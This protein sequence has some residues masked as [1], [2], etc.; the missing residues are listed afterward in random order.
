MASRKKKRKKNKEPV[1]PLGGYSLESLMGLA[2]VSVVKQRK[3]ILGLPFRLVG[4]LLKLP[5]VLLGLPFK[6]L[7]KI[8]GRGRKETT[9]EAK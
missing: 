7:G 9:T 2:P 4:S 6:L 8:F 3:S 5:F 1:D